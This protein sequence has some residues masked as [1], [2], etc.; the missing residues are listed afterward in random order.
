MSVCCLSQDNERRMERL[1]ARRLLHTECGE[2]GVPLSAPFYG[3]FGL[4]MRWLH[5]HCACPDA[6]CGL[7]MTDRAVFT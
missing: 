1:Y 3:K 5:R 4:G 2:C 6:M 7:Y